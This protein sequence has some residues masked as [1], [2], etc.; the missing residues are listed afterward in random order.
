MSVEIKDRYSDEEI[1]NMQIGACDNFFMSK[2]SAMPI[3]PYQY[4]FF[5]IICVTNVVF[6]VLTD[7]ERVNDIEQAELQ[8]ITFPA[9]LVIY[10][11]FTNIVISSGY[12][13]GYVGK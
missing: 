6:S 2:D 12:A 9:G 5:E 7:D 4:P 10:G 3:A 13:I 11:R 1:R 8:T